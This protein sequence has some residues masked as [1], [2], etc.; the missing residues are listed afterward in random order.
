MKGLEIPVTVEG[1]AD[2]RDWRTWEHIE[3]TFFFFVLGSF[4]PSKSAS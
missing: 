3:H 4:Y 1:K 2:I